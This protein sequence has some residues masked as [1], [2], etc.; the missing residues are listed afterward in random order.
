[1]STPPLPVLR[2]SVLTL[3]HDNTELSKTSHKHKK[4]R[5][6]LQLENVTARNSH[7]NSWWPPLVSCLVAKSRASGESM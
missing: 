5:L 6:G 2:H 4:A 3:S 1:M 7:A